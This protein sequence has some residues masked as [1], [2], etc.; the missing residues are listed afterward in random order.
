MNELS[1]LTVSELDELLD[2]MG[3][4]K[5]GLKADKVERLQDKIYVE[6]I[7]EVERRKVGMDE[8]EVKD[9]EIRMWAGKIPVYVCGHCGRQYDN[10]DKLFMH[11]LYH[12]PEDERNSKLDELIKE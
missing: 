6:E 12:Y 3:L 4:S 8:P 9:Y 1:K 7:S 5:D 2:M 11:I 10:R